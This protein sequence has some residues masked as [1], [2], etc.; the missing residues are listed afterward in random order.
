[1]EDGVEAPKHG[2]RQDDVAVLATNVQ[3]PQ[4]IVRDAPDE[5]SDPVQSWLVQSNPPLSHT[6]SAVSPNKLSGQRSCHGIAIPHLLLERL[7][8]ESHHVRQF[9]RALQSN[10]GVTVA[11]APKVGHVPSQALGVVKLVEGQV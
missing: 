2:H 3:V 7:P 1:L 10:L 5:A 9:I 4:D 6:S 8:Y 11:P